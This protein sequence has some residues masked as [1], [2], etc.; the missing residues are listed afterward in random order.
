MGK[1]DLKIWLSDPITRDY[2]NAVEAVMDNL[3]QSFES[4]GFMAETNEQVLRNIFRHEGKRELAAIF[5][6]PDKF[7]NEIGLVK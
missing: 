4:F 2:F 5:S 3:E 6:N 7:L 1:D